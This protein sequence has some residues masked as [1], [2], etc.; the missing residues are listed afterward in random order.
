[1]LLFFQG[2]DAEGHAVTQRDRLLSMP[3]GQSV[4]ASV[5][6]D[7]Y[8]AHCM[9]CHGTLDDNASPFKG[10]L[11]IDQVPFTPL[12]YTTTIA[13]NN[14]AA[15]LSASSP[16]PAHFLGAI[17]P[18]LD[19]KCVGCHSG[20]NPGGELSLEATYSDIG[21]YPKGKWATIPGLADPDY[22]SF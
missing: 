15:D 11:E 3:P 20:Q 22:L 12:D 8:T 10:L 2:I 17:R 1:K 21:N 4:N 14:P 7:Q 18:L 19:A 9:S 16:T 13:Y 6:A 5:K